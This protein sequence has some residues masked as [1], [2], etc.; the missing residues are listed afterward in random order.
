MDPQIR[1]IISELEEV[2]AK[3]VTVITLEV[4]AN[5]IE[6]TPVD[7]GW[8]RAN[9]VPNIGGPFEAFVSEFDDDDARKAA[10][11]GQRGIQQQ[12][13]GLLVAGGYNINQG[14]VYVTNNVPYIQVLNTGSSTQAPAAFIQ[15]AIETGV[16]VA[17]RKVSQ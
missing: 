6:L 7:T 11:P 3:A 12:A 2:T 14:A 16:N 15:N 9:W 13:T 10:V 8:A 17:A 1:R 5:L 4:A